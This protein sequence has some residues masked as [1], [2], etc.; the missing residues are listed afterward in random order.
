M[1]APPP[2]RHAESAAADLV[3]SHTARS[4][5]NL[6]IEGVRTYAPGISMGTVDVFPAF[7]TPS[8]APPD[9]CSGGRLRHYKI[10]CLFKINQVYMYCKPSA[11]V[12][13][14]L[15]ALGSHMSGS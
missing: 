3:A 1:V 10:I 12:A 2:P 15:P 9:G 14:F 6:S 13:G 4:A 5:P 8:P 7:S 11:R